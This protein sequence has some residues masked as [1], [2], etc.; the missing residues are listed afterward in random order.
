MM[1]LN[2]GVFMFEVVRDYLP[3]IIVPCTPKFLEF[4][5]VDPCFDY[6]FILLIHRVSLFHVLH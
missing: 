5:R 3:A 1:G 6:V 2:E 4:M